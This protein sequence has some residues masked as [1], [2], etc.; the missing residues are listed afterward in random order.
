MQL[1]CRSF[2]ID[3]TV[4]I[5][6]THQREPLC[7]SLWQRRILS[8]QASLMTVKNAPVDQ[9][10]RMAQSKSHGGP[11]STKGSC[12]C[13]RFVSGRAARPVSDAE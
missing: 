2:H 5:H 7:L 4:Q 9:D 6:S 8:Q 1:G 11:Q 12:Q 13:H 10:W 3:L